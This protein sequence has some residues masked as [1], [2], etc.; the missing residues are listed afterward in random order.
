MITTNP[1]L[2]LIIDRVIKRVGLPRVDVSP[3]KTPRARPST[4]SRAREAWALAR[5]ISAGRA[6]V[7]RPLTGARVDAIRHEQVTPFSRDLDAYE[8]ETD[9]SE[10]VAALGREAR[11][12]PEQVGPWPAR[13]LLLIEALG[14]GADRARADTSSAPGSWKAR[15]ARRDRRA[16]ED[17]PDA[18]FSE[19]VAEAIVKIRWRLP[20]TGGTA[21]ASPPAP[22][23]ARPTH[24]R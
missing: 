2:D 13:H 1:R 18:W 14:R 10:E 7:P 15:L 8:D 20:S 22:G 4:T 19:V 9:L 12:T 16:L 23:Y 21:P 3:T 11:A 6:G 24:L 5:R 17:L